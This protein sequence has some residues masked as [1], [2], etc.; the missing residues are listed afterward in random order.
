MWILE[1]RWLISPLTPKHW[2]LYVS[3]QFLSFPLKTLL[4]KYLKYKKGIEELSLL[5]SLIN[6][7][8]HKSM[9]LC[10]CPYSKTF[11]SFPRSN[12][13]LK[14]GIHYS[15]IYFYTYYCI[16][17][18]THKQYIALFLN[19]KK[20]HCTVYILL[21]F[22]HSTFIL[23]HVDITSHC[24]SSLI[25]SLLYNKHCKTAQ[26]FIYPVLQTE[27]CWQVSTITNNA[28]IYTGIHVSF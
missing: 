4:I 8:R 22:F 6:I 5:D 19:Y 25:F 18:C 17:K 27:D 14:F 15:Y 28:A 20:Q 12:N 7:D 16:H 3:N 11:S 23:A 21:Q 26:R 2:H 1:H 10:V 13:H 24:S 9:V